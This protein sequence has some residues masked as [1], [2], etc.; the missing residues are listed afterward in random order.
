LDTL[1][2]DGQTNLWAGIKVALDML[3]NNFKAG[4][5]HTSILLLTDGEPNIFPP[6]GFIEQ[7]QKYKAKY[8]RFLFSLNTF[9]IGKYTDSKLLYDLA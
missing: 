2:A 7:L 8:P 9:S 5:R 3:R 6:S 1:I 4:N